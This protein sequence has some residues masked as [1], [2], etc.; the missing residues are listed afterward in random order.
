MTTHKASDPSDL[1]EGE[2]NKCKKKKVLE[3]DHVLA[4]SLTN[5]EEVLASR[6]SGPHWRQG[7]AAT[8]WRQVCVWNQLA[9]TVCHTANV[10]HCQRGT[11]FYKQCAT[12]PM[13]HTVSV[14][15]TC[16]NSVEP[17]CFQTATGGKAGTSVCVYKNASCV[18]V[19]LCLS[20]KNCTL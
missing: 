7:R 1:A 14:E 10:P 2:A 9:P 17:T 3:T 8:G 19:Y 6:W 20:N 12:L 18:S 5:T 16:T 15:P 4:C 13:C 11:N